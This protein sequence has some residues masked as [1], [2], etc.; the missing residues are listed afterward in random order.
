MTRF[1][2]SPRSCQ[3]C[4][5]FVSQDPDVDR[6]AT[7][8]GIPSSE[9]AVGMLLVSHTSGPPS[10]RWMKGPWA[11]LTAPTWKMPGKSSQPIFGNFVAQPELQRLAESA[12]VMLQCSK[13]KGSVGSFKRKEVSARGWR[14]TDLVQ[15][16]GAMRCLCVCVTICLHLQ[17]KCYSCITLYQHFVWTLP[18]QRQP[19]LSQALPTAS[20]IYN[21]PPCSNSRWLPC[22]NSWLP[23]L[24]ITDADSYCPKDF[25]VKSEVVV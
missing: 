1:P 4:S 12:D 8:T 18:T 3:A 24:H 13:Q 15:Q 17:V 11:P 10:T 25:W 9:V 7:S 23:A 6:E 2:S 14:G 5:M 19:Q 20:R 21:N 22:W 16:R